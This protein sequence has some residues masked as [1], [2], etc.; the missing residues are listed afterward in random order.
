MRLTPSTATEP[1]GIS[2]GASAGPGTRLGAARR[3]SSRHE[4]RHR[5]DAVDV[6]QDQV[7]AEPPAEPQRP[8][9]VDRI[10]GAELAERGARERLGPEVEARA[11]RRRA[12][13][14]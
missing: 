6:A 13:P 5:A 9:E 14:R 11:G 1:C 2:S 7:A 8:L 12:R 10:A 4:S 3:R